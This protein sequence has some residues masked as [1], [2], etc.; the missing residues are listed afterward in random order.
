[1]KRQ[2]VFL[3]LAALLFAAIALAPGFYVNLL[4]YVGLYSLVAVGLVLLTGVAGVTSFG[5]AAFVGIAAYTTAVMT[6][7]FGLSPWLSLPACLA[8][9]GLS[10]WIL[11][12]ITFR[13]SGHYLALGTMAW[14]LGLFYIMGDVA[15]L[16]GHTGIPGVPRLPLDL[17][18]EYS[19]RW[20]AVLIWAVAISVIIAIERILAS[21]KG[22]AIRALKSGQQ[23]A[24]SF[25][26]NTYTL[27]IQIFVFT[28]LVAG[29]AGW[30]YA[31]YIGFVNPTPF[32]I[33]ASIEYLFMAVLGGAGYVWGAVLG[34]GIITL[35]RHWLQDVLPLVLGRSGNFDIVV[36]G[37]ILM[38]VLHRA[39]N[40]IAP[41][42]ARYV[43][44]TPKEPPQGI[45]R[46]MP[47]R[48]Q[49]DPAAPLL[50]LSGVT[51]KF[52]GLVAVNQ[53]SFSLKNGEILGLIGPNGAGK[54][55]TF[56]LV[57]NVLAPTSGEVRYAGQRID[58][59]G[60]RNIAR[61]GI[62]RTFQ[63][64]QLVSDRSVLENVALGAYLH[65]KRGLT[66]AALRLDQNEEAGLLA[67][68]AAQ[69]RRVGLADKMHEAAGSLALGQQR[70]IEV[71]RALVT[72]PTLL[73]LDEPA[74]G[75]RH[76][77]KQQ[78]AQLLKDLRE[79]GVSILLVEHDMDFVMN[80]VDR[81]VVMN[82][83][84]KLASGEP[85]QIRNNPSVIEAYLGGEA[86]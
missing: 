61:L 50:E 48:S 9:S 20:Y 22:R 64:V 15:A 37:V 55:T 41:V 80:L 24:E 72:G 85:R 58:G 59:T 78:L 74:A 2:T 56:N 17:L 60:M 13:L 49:P 84:E 1:M 65:G 30:L 6:T 7:T 35:L 52:G 32:G 26:V 70:L 19:G 53:L 77:E 38:L 73:L 27:K 23:M 31:H 83:G 62:A 21:R 40:G 79:D 10:A 18:Y 67:A 14:G 46:L 25:G 69:V 86:A 68:A 47:R 75:L 82:F 81:L 66:S 36:L 54:S 39:R 11:G 3:C 16:G 45:T 5:Q 71:A 42:L 12:A 57:T 76:L 4:A 28:G 8:L 33:Y 43:R 29:L 63:H 44:S 51:R 34:A